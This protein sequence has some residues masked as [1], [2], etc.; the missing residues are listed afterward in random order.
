MKKLLLVGLLSSIVQAHTVTTEI[1][2]ENY[3]NEKNDK[4]EKAVEKANKI[5]I[6]LKTFTT[7]ATSVSTK[8]INGEIVEHKVSVIG[9]IASETKETIEKTPNT[10]KEA[11]KEYCFDMLADVLNDMLSEKQ[12]LI[13]LNEKEKS[14]E[15]YLINVIFFDKQDE[16]IEQIELTMNQSD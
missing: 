15:H 14:P 4:L 13:N 8:E 3:I 6:Y 1:E 11:W 10:D 5:H 12:Y 2:L 9:S 7:S 16:I